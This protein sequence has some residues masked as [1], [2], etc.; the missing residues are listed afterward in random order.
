MFYLLY[1]LCERHDPSLYFFSARRGTP[2]VRR[3]SVRSKIDLHSRKNEHLRSECA[4]TPLKP[5]EDPLSV[6]E[7]PAL[8]FLELAP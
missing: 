6:E 2:G 4:V 5:P 1:L 7:Q 8:L 3:A